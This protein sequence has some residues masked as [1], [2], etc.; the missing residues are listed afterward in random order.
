MFLGYLSFLKEYEP[1]GVQKFEWDPNT[2]TLN[3][4]WVNNGASDINGVP[5]VSTDSGIVYMM[6]ARTTNGPWRA[7]TGQRGSHSSLRAGLRALQQL[8]LATGD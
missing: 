6:G 2:R 8:L 7:S 5:F 1:H 3:P 4:A